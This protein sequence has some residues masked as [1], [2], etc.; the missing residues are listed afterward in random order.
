MKNCQEDSSKLHNNNDR[1]T[2]VFN[3]LFSFFQY[4][5]RIK[6]NPIPPHEFIFQLDQDIEDEEVRI[7]ENKKLMINVIPYVLYITGVGMLFFHKSQ[8]YFDP[9]MFYCSSLAIILLSIAAKGIAKGDIVI[10]F[11]NRA[12]YSSD[13]SIAD[14]PSYLQKKIHTFLESHGTAR[15]IKTLRDLRDYC[16]EFETDNGPVHQLR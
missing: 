6:A 16:Y 7:I 1:K 13:S 4:S 9:E 14:L 10:S 11:D 3:R 8:R 5:S 12:E 15:S 2:R